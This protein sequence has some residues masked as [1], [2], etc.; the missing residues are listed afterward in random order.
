MEFASFMATLPPS[1][2]PAEQL[3]RYQAY[4]RTYAAGAA[5]AA[6]AP[7]QPLAVGAGASSSQVLIK[8][9]DRIISGII[10]KGGSVIREIAARSGATVRVSQKEAM[11]AAGERTVMIDSPNPAAIQAA[12]H[13]VHERIREVEFAIASGGPRGGGGD[14]G[15]RPS[16]IG[17]SA[18]GVNTNAAAAGYGSSYPY[19]QPSTN[20]GSSYSAPADPYAQQAAYAYSFAQQPSQPSAQPAYQPPPGYQMTNTQGGGY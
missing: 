11:T 12:E 1:I 5:G 2:E 3:Q 8:V 19:A 17:P 18:I 16:A 4:L 7:P 13:L 15:V 6:A 9:A 20:Y 14:G 10:G